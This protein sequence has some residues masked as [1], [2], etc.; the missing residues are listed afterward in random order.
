MNP[1]D[2]DNLATIRRA[3]RTS[4]LESTLAWQVRVDGLPAPEQ[5]YRFDDNRRWRFD[6]AWPDCRVAVEVNGGEWSAGRHN[7]AGGMAADYE[8][9]NAA[10]IAGWRV[11]QFTGG[12]VR[13]GVAV[14][15]IRRALAEFDV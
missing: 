7:R 9:L 1:R 4:D 11:L 5:E 15:T 6:F 14:E 12:Q 8:K 2:A 3:I 10:V 13:D